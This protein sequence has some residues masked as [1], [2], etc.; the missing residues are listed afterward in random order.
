MWFQCKEKEQYKRKYVQG[1]EGAR[2]SEPQ[3][4]HPTSEF[5]IVA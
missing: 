5:T 4:A 3:K 2:S 1:S